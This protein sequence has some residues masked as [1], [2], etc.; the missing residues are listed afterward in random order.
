MYVLVCW[1]SG[2]DGVIC[3]SQ[4]G[5]RLAFIVNPEVCLIDK[6]PEDA[7]ITSWTI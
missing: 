7:L 6:T 1:L 2:E 3:S 5:W 4:Q